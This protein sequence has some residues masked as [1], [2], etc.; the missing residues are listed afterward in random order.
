MNCFSDKKSARKYFLDKRLS[1]SAES[2]ARSSRALCEKI[3]ASE[4]FQKAD[5]VLIYYPSRNEPDL[6]PLVEI[7]VRTGK[8]IAFPISVPADCTLL[9][10]EISSIAELKVGSY[11]IPEPSV[12]APTPKITEKSLCIVPALAFDKKGFRIG[13]GKGYYDRFL[14]QFKGISL[15]AVFDCLTCEKL[16]IDTTD[17]PVNIIITETGVTRIK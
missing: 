11:S 7:A 14:S 17:V 15:G 8:K 5:V 4:D 10:R 16:P 2:I 12:T 6:T 9:F 3:S 13:Y 1:L